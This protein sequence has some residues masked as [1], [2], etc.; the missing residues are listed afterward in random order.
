MAARLATV[1]RRPREKEGQVSSN[2]YLAV[3]VGVIALVTVISV[4]SLFFKRCAGCGRR[5][6]LDAVHCRG[7]GMAFPEEPDDPA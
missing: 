6:I 4:P 3:M 2:L 1:A 7:C 5:N